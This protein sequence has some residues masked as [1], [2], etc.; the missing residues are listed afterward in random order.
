M[1]KFGSHAA[2]SPLVYWAPSQCSNSETRGGRHQTWS[3]FR[4]IDDTTVELA[5]QRLAIGGY[6]VSFR[7]IAES[8]IYI[9]WP[10]NKSIRRHFERRGA[11]YSW[12]SECLADADGDNVSNESAVGVQGCHLCT[13]T[14]LTS[15]KGHPSD[16]RVECKGGIKKIKMSIV[17][18]GGGGR[19]EIPD[20]LRHLPGFLPKNSSLR[21][22][23][24]LNYVWVGLH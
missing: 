20:R 8:M 5:I 2:C 16:L 10:I 19:A 9:H 7:R 11:A 12:R 21:S 14:Y 22:R 13:G 17:Q 24:A 1:S 18:Q 6:G 23:V 4:E 15:W 3:F